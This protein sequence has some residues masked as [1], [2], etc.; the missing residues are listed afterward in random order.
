MPMWRLRVS[1]TI[2]RARVVL[3]VPVI[4]QD[5]VAAVPVVIHVTIVVS[6]IIM[7]HDAC[8]RVSEA[9]VRGVLGVGF[10][11][12]LWQRL[13]LIPCVAAASLAILS[14]LLYGRTTA[15]RADTVLQ[16]VVTCRS[17]PSAFK[18]LWVRGWL[19]A[20]HSE[21]SQPIGHL[22]ELGTLYEDRNTILGQGPPPPSVTL[23]GSP[24]RHLRPKSSMTIDAYGTLICATG[25]PQL[26]VSRYQPG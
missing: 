19:A 16:V 21:L 17:D 15:L 20:D 7:L 11:R 9:K 2:G 5:A 6:H 23:L 10:R 13:L 24:G 18:Q 25:T 26:F 1:R 8:F 3:L 4:L 22:M 14:Y 12:Q